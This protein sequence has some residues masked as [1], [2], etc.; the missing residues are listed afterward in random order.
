MR[1]PAFST[2]LAFVRP[3]LAARFLGSL[4]QRTLALVVLRFDPPA[5]LLS[6][7]A[8]RD[9]AARCLL[10]GSRDGHRQRAVLN[11]GL[12]LVLVDVCGQRDAPLE[13]AVAALG[14]AALVLALA[15]LLAGEA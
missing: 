2:L 11:V 6:A 3:L 14:I 4:L 5:G 13:T 15:A 9:A 8:E 1:A 7:R 10:G 12:A